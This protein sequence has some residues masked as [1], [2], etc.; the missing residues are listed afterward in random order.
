MLAPRWGWGK[1]KNLSL[2]CCSCPR[3]SPVT[4]MDGH[5][6]VELLTLAYIILTTEK[7]ANTTQVHR[8]LNPGIDYLKLIAVSLYDSSM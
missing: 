1:Y 4:V 5:P 3:R 2:E 8:N 7:S 6:T